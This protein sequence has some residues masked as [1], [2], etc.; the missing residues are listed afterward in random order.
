[1]H[2]IYKN[3]DA[4]VVGYTNDG[5]H[6]YAIVVSEGVFNEA[7]LHEIHLGMQEVKVTL[8]DLKPTRKKRMV[9][10]RVVKK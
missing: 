6:S 2:V 9:S 4:S 10:K 3:K 5:T 7:R 1:M 8:S